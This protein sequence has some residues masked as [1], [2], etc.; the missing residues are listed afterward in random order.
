LKE[1]EISSPVEVSET[2]DVMS[3]PEKQSFLP[4]TRFRITQAGPEDPP[5]D[6]TGND[7]F[8]RRSASLV[9][10]RMGSAFLVE[11]SLVEKR[12]ALGRDG[13]LLSSETPDTK[14]SDERWPDMSAS[15]VEI[16]VAPGRG[17]GRS[18]DISVSMVEIGVA[19]G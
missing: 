12:M 8:D 17:K 14:P 4:P 13:A 5:S 15:M 10:K 9:E 6:K 18:S 16:G 19:A 1:T 11:N 2:A 3:S 7:L